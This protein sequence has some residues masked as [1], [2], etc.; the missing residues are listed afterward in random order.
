MLAARVGVQPRLVAFW[1]ESRYLE[2]KIPCRES[3]SAVVCTSRRAPVLE[4]RRGLLLELTGSSSQH[5]QLQGL[6]G[7]VVGRA[8]HSGPTSAMQ[9]PE[10]CLMKPEQH[11]GQRANRE[12]T[13]SC[14]IYQRFKDLHKPW[15]ALSCCQWLVILFVFLLMNSGT[16]VPQV[17]VTSQAALWF[18]WGWRVVLSAGSVNLDNHRPDTKED[19][20]T[21]ISHVSMTHNRNT[22]KAL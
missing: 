2:A 13:C 21:D 22:L 7:S 16:T 17:E 3:V 19:T 5:R 14:C 1:W 10:A 20:T 11:Q 4:P 12:L 8:S 6:I 18:G 9:W 15:K